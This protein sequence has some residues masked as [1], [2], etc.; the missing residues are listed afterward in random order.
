MS[1]QTLKS[2]RD[3]LQ[4]LL[5]LSSQTEVKPFLERVVKLACDATRADLAYLAVGAGFA[6]RTP[7]WWY[8][9][10]LEPDDVDSIRDQLS[11]TLLTRAEEDGIVETRDA[12][13]DPRFRQ[14]PSVR[15]RKIRSVLCAALTTGTRSV[16]VLYLMGQPHQLGANA[17]DILELLRRYL[18]PIVGR[19]LTSLR[20]DEPD[21]TRQYR[22][23][24]PMDRLVGHSAAL[25]T[26]MREIEVAAQAPVAVMLTGRTGTGKS[27]I[28]RVIHE[29][30]DRRERPFVSVNAAQL[31]KSLAQGELFGVKKGAFTGAEES[32]GLVTRANGGTLFLDEIVE[33]DHDVQAQLLTFTQEGIYRRVG[34]SVTRRA[35]VRLI[36]ATNEDPKQAV[37]DSKLR[38]DLMYRLAAFLIEVPALADRREDVVPI[39]FAMVDR[40]SGRFGVRARPLSASACAW[41][42]SQDWPGNI[43]ELENVIQS[44]LLWA[45]HEKAEAIRPIHFDRGASPEG[46]VAELSYKEA[47]RSFKRRFA[48]RA[49]ADAGG[50]KAAAAR[51][52]GIHR[53][54][55]DEALKAR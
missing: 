5:Q 16:G 6:S 53:D 18:G 20:G 30:S 23:R 54:T 41:L 4:A 2:E 28:A 1:D 33:L 9:H 36:T 32:E 47:V 21:P 14:Q 43:R 45:N 51:R 46:A 48:E 40:L 49:V 42:E 29:A 19:L 13:V 24:L 34:D 12:L 55:L 50:N 31:S 11:T 3:L 35:D 26:T 15:N 39:A 25:A 22:E 38:Q 10:A 52:L 8:G 17:R 44:G 7:R 37:E 27:T